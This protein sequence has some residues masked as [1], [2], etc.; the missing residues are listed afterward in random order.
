MGVRMLAVYG[1]PMGLLGLGLLVERI[2]YTATVSAATALGAVVTC[3]IALRWRAS[4][5][6]VAART[7]PA[8]Q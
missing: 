6:Q 4:V 7:R 5:W 8:P 3:L 1:Y 2:G